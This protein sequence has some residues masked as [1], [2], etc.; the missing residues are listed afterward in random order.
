MTFTIKKSQWGWTAYH[1]NGFAV[2]HSESKALLEAYLKE[3][4]T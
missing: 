4:K 1:P 3:C 2:A